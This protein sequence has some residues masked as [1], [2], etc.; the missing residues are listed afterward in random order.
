MRKFLK[1]CL[2]TFLHSC[3]CM[4]VFYTVISIIAPELFPVKILYS[5]IFGT[6]ICV[7][8][9]LLIFKIKNMNIWIKRFIAIY[10][11]AMV[12]VTFIFLF[13]IVTFA[14]FKYLT[15]LIYGLMLGEPVA[16]LM[17]I[18]ADATEKR[19]QREALE[20]INEKLGKENSDSETPGEDSPRC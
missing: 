14:P 3:G 17:Y 11:S 19:R 20:K 9:N 16:V 4:A 5:L 8:V 7:P 1:R 6:A 15:V 13:G 18:I 12:Y 2:L 10:V